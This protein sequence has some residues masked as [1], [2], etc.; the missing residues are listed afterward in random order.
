[1]VASTT[2]EAVATDTSTVDKAVASGAFTADEAMAM[3][4]STADEAMAKDTSTMDKAVVNGAFTAGQGRCCQA[5]M[6]VRWARWSQNDF[7]R[8]PT[9]NTG[10]VQ[11]LAHGAWGSVCACVILA[12]ACMHACIQARM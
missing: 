8:N 11:P 2:D 3:V 4:V 9:P 12:H 5:H 6:S 1:M 7:L 10:L